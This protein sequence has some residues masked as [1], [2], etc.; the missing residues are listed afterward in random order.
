MRPCCSLGWRRKMRALIMGV[1]VR[2]TTAETM[3]VTARV[4]ANSRN[5]RPTTSPINNSG[6][7]T[8]IRDRSEERRGGNDWSSDVCSSDRGDH[9]RNDDGDGEG[10]GKLAEQAPHNVAHKQQRNQY[11]DKG[12]I[13]RATWRE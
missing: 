3:M 1:S 13:G 7:S 8:A 2:E 6:I 4:T 12:Q 10:R 9:G 5:R 11:G